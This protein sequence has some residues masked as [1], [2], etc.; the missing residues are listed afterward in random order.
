MTTAGAAPLEFAGKIRWELLALW[1]GLRLMC[2]RLSLMR[3]GRMK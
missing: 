2:P 1:F 3:M